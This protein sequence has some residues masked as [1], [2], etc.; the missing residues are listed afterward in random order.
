M[1]S[2]RNFSRFSHTSAA[3]SH[4]CRHLFHPTKQLRENFFSFSQIK[5]CYWGYLY[6]EYDFFV[7]SIY[8][9]VY[10]FP[11]RMLQNASE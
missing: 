2:C 6:I 5:A 11:C 10:R 7:D 1:I 9:D 8:Q 4:P 3:I